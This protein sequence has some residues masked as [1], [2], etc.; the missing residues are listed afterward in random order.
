MYL[1]STG[2]PVAY[3]LQVHTVHLAMLRLI[4]GKLMQV[5]YLIAQ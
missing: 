5:E 4:A 1:A 2:L 3:S